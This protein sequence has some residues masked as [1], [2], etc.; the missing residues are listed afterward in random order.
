MKGLEIQVEFFHHIILSTTINDNEK[1]R[2]K[3]SELREKIYAR[4]L[5]GNRPQDIDRNFGV[6][7]STVYNVKKLYDETGSFAKRQNGSRPRSTRTEELV[8]EVRGQIE[9]NPQTT[10]TKLARE[11]MVSAT[12]MSE[13]VR[14]DLG[15][16]SIAVVPV[17][18][19]TAQQRE[20]RLVRSKAILNWMKRKVVGPRPVL[21][22]SDE[23]NFY[24]CLLYTSDAADE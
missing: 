11:N 7:R 6:A 8:E 9:Q 5:A 16:K 14:Q 2:T 12:T 10:V 4:I 18:M 23:K 21:V 13:L 24:L 22:F 3:M 20:K 19:L 1:K 17:Q 15:M